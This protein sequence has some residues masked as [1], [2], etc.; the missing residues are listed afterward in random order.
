MQLIQ[1]GSKGLDELLGGG[2]PK[3]KCVLVVGS[4]GAGKTILLMQ[5][6]KSGAV[7][8][9]RGLYVAMDE[10]PEHV[11][12]NLSPFNWNLEKLEAEGRLLFLD[13]TMLRGTGASRSSGLLLSG[14]G[15]EAEPRMTVRFL[16]DTIRRIVK[17][18]DI[19]RI[20]V[21]PI[22]SIMLRYIDPYKRRRAMLMFF[23]SLLGLGC[24]SLVST[25]L[26]TSML[27][28]AFQVEEFLSQ[29]VILMHT[30]I[31]AGSLVRAVQIEKMRGIPHDAQLRP[32]QITSNGIEVYPKDR[33]F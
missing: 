15:I 32:Y 25:E 28:R 27:R 14:E 19:Q 20:A 31:H 8:D 7:V 10:A 22:T 24:T 16:I 18:E 3:G 4:P 30:F 33:V 11:K 5:F 23:D 2:L 6:L 12:A 26:R 17:E 29:G 9:E 1:T 13:A 21:D